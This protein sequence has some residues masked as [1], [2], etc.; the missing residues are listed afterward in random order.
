MAATVIYGR[1]HGGHLGD[2]ITRQ[3]LMWAGLLLVLG[4]MGSRTNNLAHLGGFGFGYLTARFFLPEAEHR[5][6]I[7]VVTCALVLALGSILSVV[8]S[9]VSFVPYFL[10]S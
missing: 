1:A 7:G 9:L 5:E 3:A 6:G 10:K 8:L 4:F 2:A